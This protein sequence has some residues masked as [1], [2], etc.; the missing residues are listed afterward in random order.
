M[1][2]TNDPN[3]KDLVEPLRRVGFDPKKYSTLSEHDQR[4]VMRMA[5]RLSNAEAT[6]EPDSG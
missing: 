6:V 2:N 5:E 4:I 1:D 3:D